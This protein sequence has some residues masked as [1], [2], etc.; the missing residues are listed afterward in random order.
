MTDTVSVQLQGNEILA[1]SQW[2]DYI[3]R[4][5]DKAFQMGFYQYIRDTY[6][7]KKPEHTSDPPPWEEKGSYHSTHP[8]HATHFRVLRRPG[9]NYIAKLV[10]GFFPDKRDTDKLEWYSVWV[11]ALFLP[12]RDLRSMRMPSESWSDAATRLLNV[13]TDY[14][15]DVRRWLS[16]LQYRHEAEK[17]AKEKR[18]EPN[19]HQGSNNGDEPVM[20]D[21]LD[22]EEYA[23][24]GDDVEVNSDLGQGS[25][26][27]DPPPW[28]ANR[29]DALYA[30]T[31]MGVAEEYGIFSSKTNDVWSA[32]DSIVRR[33]TETD[34]QKLKEWKHLLD[35]EETW[36]NDRASDLDDEGSIV[37]SG[38]DPCVE[39]TVEHVP[40]DSHRELLPDQQRAFSIIVDQL[41]R[42]TEG[43]DQEPL[44]MMV[45]GEGGTGKSEII[46]AVTEL[47]SKRGRS[48]ALI[49]T[50]YTGIACSQIAGSTTHRVFEFGI[51]NAESRTGEL[52]KYDGLGMTRHNRLVTRFKH[53]TWVII[54]EIS[55]ISLA[56]FATIARRLDIAKSGTYHSREGTSFGNI[57][58]ILF[59]DF[60]QFPPINKTASLY[61]SMYGLN[62]MEVIGKQLYLSFS[63]VVVLQQQVRV[64]DQGWL[65]VLRALRHGACTV[66]THIPLIQSLVLSEK[67]PVD[68]RVHPWSEA[69]LITPRHSVRILWNARALR[70]MCSAT[71]RTLYIVPA[72]DI[73]RVP[74]LGRRALTKHERAV[75]A[76]LS[77][78]AKK[79]DDTVEIA[80]GMKCMITWN[81]RTESD[82]ANGTVGEIVD[83]V[84]DKREPEPERQ[85]SVIRLLFPPRYILVRPLFT[86]AQSL[87]G[88]DAGVFPIE[89][90]EKTFHIFTPEGTKIAVSRYQIPITGA[91]AMTDYRAQG[92]TMAAAIV[93]LA[94]PPTGSGLT[95]FAAY[96]AL[97]RSRGRENIRILR[98]FDPKLFTTHPSEALRQEYRRLSKLDADTKSW[99]NM[100]RSQTH[101]SN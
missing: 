42:E 28:Q 2:N 93:D 98:E 85:G 89:P 88:L 81:V 61:A 37:I 90:L 65:D 62:E 16:N 19:D 76:S 57:N 68:F 20:D 71:R 30:R 95:P 15:S 24:D 101:D 6:E 83:L 22:N 82:L 12:L 8:R 96:V 48:E 36:V 44:R 27:I 56:T 100:S 75:V 74:G 1:H 94:K 53:V 18:E 87:P 40:F 14:S 84:M 5:D 92:Q 10:G 67:N 54:D 13:P 66:H 11:I 69:R 45:F 55:M 86:S 33:A 99:W 38:D 32:N 78:D 46:K 63:R 9:H 7:R 64:Q 97:S 39:P 3:L 80:V 52:D 31:A 73:A 4:P 60:A 35:V 29:K 79:L 17:S 50:A 49:K 34:D 59:G 91:Y 21:V 23:G 41:D 47:F 70:E 77:P 58:L 51:R 72:E 43:L 26:E 25:R